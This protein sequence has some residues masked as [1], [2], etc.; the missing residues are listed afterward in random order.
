MTATDVAMTATDV[1][2]TATDVG[3]LPATPIRHRQPPISINHDI[4]NMRRYV[5]QGERCCTGQTRRSAPTYVG[6]MT[7]RRGDRVGGVA[8]NAPT[9]VAPHPHNVS[10]Y[11]GAT[12]TVA[13]VQRGGAYCATIFLIV[14]MLIL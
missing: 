6:M 3:A 12:F 8:G 7:G 4:R 11:V 2:M 13:P 5:V 10:P 14:V 9:I 1:A